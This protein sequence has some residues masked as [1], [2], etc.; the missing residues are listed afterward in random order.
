MVEKFKEYCEM[1]YTQTEHVLSNMLYMMVVPMK[2]AEMSTQRVLGVFDFIQRISD[3]YDYETLENV[4]YSYQNKLN[5]LV[6][7][8]ENGVDK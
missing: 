7:K 5:L 3:N 4:Y 1:E 2:V 6:K 8:Y